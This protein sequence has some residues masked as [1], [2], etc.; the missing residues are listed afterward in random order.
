MVGF[1]RIYLYKSGGYH[2]VHLGDKFNDRYA[3]EHKLDSG[4][5]STVWLA[6]DLQQERVVA[7]KL[8]IADVPD[9]GAEFLRRLSPQ[10]Q[11]LRLGWLWVT[12]PFGWGSFN[13]SRSF[14]LDG[15]IIHSP[16]GDHR[17]LVT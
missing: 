16:N 8:I 14:F 3:A 4:A 2:P 7:L 17:Y 6:R 13:R 15:F 12:L 9:N 10:S 5:F 11:P 1:E